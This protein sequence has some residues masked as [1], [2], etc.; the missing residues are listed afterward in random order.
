MLPAKA[1]TK[2]MISH[3]IGFGGYPW[4]P[5]VQTH[6]I[7]VGAQPIARL[8]ARLKNDLRENRQPKALI[9]GTL[10]SKPFLVGG[11]NPPEKYQSVGMTILNIWENKKCSKPP[12]RF[13]IGGEYHRVQSMSPYP[14]C[15]MDY[16]LM[17][18]YEGCLIVWARSQMIPCGPCALRYMD[19]IAIKNK[20]VFYINCAG[21]A[22]IQY[23]CF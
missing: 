17:M 19:F 9:Y 13:F 20:C 3:W 2:I 6:V 11:L 12:T 16:R 21:Q 7:P 22:T 18:T 10:S 14:L 1:L 15:G 8:S 5:Y 4:A 23:R